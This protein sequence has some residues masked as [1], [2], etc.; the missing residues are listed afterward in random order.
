MIKAGKLRQRFEIQEATESRDSF[1]DAPVT[2]S[3]VAERW[4]QL[5]PSTGV[6]FWRAQQVQPNI[7]AMIRLRYFDGLTSRH[8]LKMGSRIFNISGVINTDE[9]KREHVLTCSEG[10]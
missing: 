9:R 7:S 5:M 4:G 10:V 2:F 3:T 8:R 6:E 1:G